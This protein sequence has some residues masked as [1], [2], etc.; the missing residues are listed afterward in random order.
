MRSQ[1][2]NNYN[3]IGTESVELY[4]NFV[5]DTYTSAT[6][7]LT[8]SPDPLWTDNEWEG[9]FLEWV[10][11]AVNVPIRARRK[12]ISQNTSDSISVAFPQIN[13]SVQAIQPGD[14]YRIVAPAA[15]FSGV[16]QTGATSAFTGGSVYTLNV[17]DTQDFT[18]E[19]TCTLE[20]VEFSYDL[21]SDQQTQFTGGW[22]MN[23]VRFMNPFNR[24]LY[25]DFCKAFL[26]AG[27]RGEGTAG[28]Q[29]WGITVLSSGGF[30][31]P[32]LYLTNGSS[33]KI[34]IVGGRMVA[35]GSSLH[36]LNGSCRDSGTTFPHGT[37]CALNGANVYTFLNTSQ[38]GYRINGTDGHDFVCEDGGRIAIA[39]P[40]VHE[41][42]MGF[43]R[44]RY[45][46]VARIESEPILGPG[47]SNLEL[48]AEYNSL[49]RLNVEGTSFGQAV[50]GA[51]PAL[52]QVIRP[53]GPWVSGEA[54]CTF[55]DFPKDMANI[56][57][58]P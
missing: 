58:Y 25:I 17:N 23:G 49:I 12:L 43:I 13:D 53:P 2:P 39:A 15:F 54:V 44:T 51:A 35:R 33:G 47:G 28:P 9:A 7:T 36:W 4:A 29:G 50:A 46:G 8:V 45:N 42:S 10:S 18:Y 38:G 34:T 27:S 24:L 21:D 55:A 37:V 56:Y 22:T 52:G 40:I 41:S 14:V 32:D 26:E 48:R 1:E 19:D 5:V 6:R 30:R 3:V 16:S 31:N 57:R 20:N 11:G